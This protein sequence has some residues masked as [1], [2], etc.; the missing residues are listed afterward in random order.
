ME[1]RTLKQ[2]HHQLNWS[3]RI[4]TLLTVA[5][6]AGAFLFNAWST[7]WGLTIIVALAVVLLVEGL[8]VSLHRHPA[9]WRVIRWMVLLILLALLL[10]GAVG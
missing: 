7:N 1:K 5:V 8:A 9:G 3:T 10:I 4:Y 2:F 6:V